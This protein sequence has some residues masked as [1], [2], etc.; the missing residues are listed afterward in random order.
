MWDTTAEMAGAISG[1]YLGLEAIPSN[2]AHHM[3]EPG[4]WGFSELV[5]LAYRCYRLNMELGATALPQ[6]IRHF[7]QR[8]LLRRGGKGISSSP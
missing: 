4:A 1:A 8:A 5:E 6:R 2:L 7:V 3:T